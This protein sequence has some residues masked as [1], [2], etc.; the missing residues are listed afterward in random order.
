MF[1]TLAIFLLLVG[2]AT[3]QAGALTDCSAC[4][5]VVSEVTKLLN[6]SIAVSDILTNVIPSVCGNDLYCSAFLNSAGPLIAPLLS[7]QIDPTI[8]CKTCDGG[9]INGNKCNKC[10][11]T[12][13]TTRN[14]LQTN[15]ALQGYLT[16]LGIKDCS[17]IS[18][19][20]PFSVGDCTKYVGYYAISLI[21][22]IADTID[23]SY[24]CSVDSSFC[25]LPT[26]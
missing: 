7:T 12:V 19:P 16:K 25:P 14:Q 13:V 4:A 20:P 2:L 6:D 10:I 3:R 15:S 5:L 18:I 22:A 23:P 9:I 17:Q 21:K 11:E 1:K 26:A 8:V 24:T